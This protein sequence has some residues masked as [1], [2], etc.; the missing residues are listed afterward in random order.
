MQL[1]R[2]PLTIP[3][4]LR[5]PTRLAVYGALLTEVRGLRNW[6][7]ILNIGLPLTGE[8]QRLWSRR[9]SWLTLCVD[10]SPPLP[11]YRT[12]LEWVPLTNRRSDRS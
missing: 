8:F 5:T 3:L 9:N 2:A 4:P 11:S 10:V 6:Q 7:I 12:W 1:R